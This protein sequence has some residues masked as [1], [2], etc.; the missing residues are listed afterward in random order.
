MG[1]IRH[2]PGSLTMSMGIPEPERD[3]DKEGTAV[4]E[5]GAHMLKGGMVSASGYI[6]KTVSNGVVITDEMAQRAEL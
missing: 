4:H 5:V 6:G 2:C 3:E 1:V